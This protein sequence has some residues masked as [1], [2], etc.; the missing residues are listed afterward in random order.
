MIGFLQLGETAQLIEP[1]IVLAVPWSVLLVYVGVVGLMLILS[2]IWATRR[3]SARRMSEV[4]R[5][6]ER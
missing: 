4:L 3:V 2:V 5:E 1:S 6:V